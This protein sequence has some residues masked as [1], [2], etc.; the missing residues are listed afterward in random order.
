MRKVMTV[1]G[2]DEMPL[3]VIVLYG[4]RQRFVNFAARRATRKIK[5]SSRLNNNFRNVHRTKNLFNPI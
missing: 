4:K 5:I 1:A 3:T 2:I